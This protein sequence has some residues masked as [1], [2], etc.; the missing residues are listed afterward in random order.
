MKLFFILAC[1]AV[2]LI[3]CRVPVDAEAPEETYSVEDLLGNWTLSKVDYLA[4]KQELEKFRKLEMEMDPE[5]YLPVYVDASGILQPHNPGQYFSTEDRDLVIEHDSLYFLN[6]PLQLHMRQAF[7]F[8]D[9]VLEYK[10]EE[11]NV[12]VSEDGQTMTL[13]YV[14]AYGL[15]LVETW[16]KAQFDPKV[17]SVLKKYALNYP[18]LAGKWVLIRESS[19]AYGNEYQLDFDYTI[20]DEIMISKE[21]LE[22]TLDTDRSYMLLTSGKKRKYFL[23]FEEGELQLVPDVWYDMQ[24][25]HDKGYPGDFYLRFERPRVEE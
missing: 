23:R 2:F 13:S 3:Q 10:G 5:N 20:P 8:K 15:Y 24:A 21:E 17:W 19:D 9:N 16:K 25:W 7:Q 6:Y 12:A 11:R 4:D 18:E 1:T 14:D 22:S